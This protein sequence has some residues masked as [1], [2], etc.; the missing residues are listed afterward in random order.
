MKCKKKQTKLNATLNL[1]EPMLM[2]EYSCFARVQLI[3]DKEKK[4]NPHLWTAETGELCEHWTKQVC[5]FMCWASVFVFT[6]L[7]QTFQIWE[8]I[9]NINLQCIS[10]MN[11]LVF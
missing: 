11:H 2:S 5:I 8:T 3:C 6:Q 9:F 4:E 10:F 7:R 1:S